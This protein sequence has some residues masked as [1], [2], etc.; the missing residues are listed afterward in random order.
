MRGKAALI[1]SLQ[2]TSLYFLGFLVMAS[3]ASREGDGFQAIQGRTFTRPIRTEDPF[4][5]SL[6]PLIEYRFDSQSDFSRR[7]VSNRGSTRLFNG[8]IVGN[9]QLVAG[10]LGN[11]ISH[12]GQTSFVE[13]G[14]SQYL[15]FRRGV[16]VEAFIWRR[17][18][19]NEDAIASKWYGWGD[20]WLLTF[21]ADG[22]GR[23]VFGVRLRD[24]TYASVEYSPDDA[25]YLQN[26]V[27]VAATYDGLG[28]LRLYWNG[29]LVAETLAE[30]Q[31]LGPGNRPIH[32]GDAGP[33]WS[34]FDGEIDEVQ[35]WP[36]ALAPEELA[37]PLR[38]R[39][40]VIEY[41][42]TDPT[43]N[44]PREISDNLIENIREA[45][46]GFVEFSIA[47]W[48]V[49]NLLPPQREGGGFD[50]AGVFN[51]FNVCPLASQG[52]IHEVWIW[53][54]PDGG[55][56]E[57]AINGPWWEAYGLGVGMPACNIQ[58]VVMGLNYERQLPEAMH[59]FGHRLEQIFR[60]HWGQYW[61]AFDGQY[62]RYGYDIQPPLE[63]TGQ[64][65]GNVHFPP[66]ADAHYEHGSLDVVSSNA[67]DWHSDESGDYLDLD[68]EAWGCTEDGFLFWWMSH[69]PG[70]RNTNGPGGTPLPNWWTAVVE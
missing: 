28:L 68:C 49:T 52:D 46:D 10:V 16:T 12:D 33:D 67:D 5:R 7:V 8:R 43:Y 30:G 45:T 56:L 19:E 41:D 61:D 57:Y 55:L 2:R 22:D 64:H 63:T 59:S 13:V 6:R 40:L 65:C 26:W 70:A 54:G 44:D 42:S 35:I 14:R 32:I 51:T 17:A 3:V 18:N 39:V 66:N 9:A 20:Q 69:M 25:S 4:L 53:A 37:R 21:Y 36:R 23:L 50:Y 34:R 11:G 47:D 62:E 38:P 29:E 27:H 1:K 24:R 48:K 58:M 31:G 60:H 15:S